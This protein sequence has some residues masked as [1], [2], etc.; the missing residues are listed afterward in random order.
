MSNLM[1]ALEI[2]LVGMGLVCAA[3]TLLWGVMALLTTITEARE[4]GSHPAESVSVMDNNDKARVAAVAV[5][6][7]LAQRQAASARPLSDSP[8]AIVSAWQLGM[9]TKQLSQKGERI[10]RQSRKTG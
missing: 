2:T 10:K 5:A 7:T 3:L 4:S 8:T 1:I 6:L 9:R